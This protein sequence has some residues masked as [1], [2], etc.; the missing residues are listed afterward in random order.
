MLFKKK[1]TAKEIF[2]EYRKKNNEAVKFIN[3]TENIYI[4]EVNPRASRTVPFVAKAT[5]IP[6][7]KIASKVM[8]GDL[9]KNLLL[10]LND[11]SVPLGDLPVVFLNLP[12][13]L[14]SGNSKVAIVKQP[15]LPVP[16][17]A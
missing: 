11:V 3:R 4:L 15:V 1:L 6:I 5:G 13:I 16:D 10:V 7:A 12:A 9:L 14:V 17:C 2:S 8:T